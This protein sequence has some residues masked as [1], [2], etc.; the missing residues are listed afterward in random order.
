MAA[1]VHNVHERALPVP[2]A[3][4]G[5]LLDRVGAADDPLWPAGWAPMRFDRPLAVGADGGHGSIRYHVTGYQPGR[6]V[7]LTFHPV[8]GLIGT[9]TLEIEERGPH[10]CVVRHRLD[11][12]PVGRMRLLWPAIV[13]VCHDTVLEHLLDN[14]EHAVTGAVATPVRYPWRARVAVALERPRARAVPVPAAATLLAAAIHRPGLADAFAV[15][16]PPGTTTDPQD[17]ADAIFRN[18]PGTVRAL[19]HLRNRLVTPLGIERDDATAFDTIVRSDREALLGSDARH[20]DFRASVLVTGE[21]GGT[22]VTVSTRAAARNRA[23]RAYLAVVRLAHPWVVRAMLR[24][25]ARTVQGRAA[26][27]AAPSTGLSDS[28]VEAGPARPEATRDRPTR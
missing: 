1:M 8:T 27:Q 24:R 20:L 11:A 18:P 10:A 21:P 2:A 15:R 22:T 16:V 12:R 23:G 5:R 28:P 19:L 6:R 7:E 26:H 9:H 3:E 14:A 4:A 13:R 25:A 17:W